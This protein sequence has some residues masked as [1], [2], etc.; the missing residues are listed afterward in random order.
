VV[1]LMPLISI[2]VALLSF[3]IFGAAAFFVIYL[4]NILYAILC[5]ADERMLKS[6]GYN[7]GGLFI[8]ALIFIPAYLY[9]RANLVKQ[10]KLPVMIWCITFAV[11]IVVYIGEL[12]NL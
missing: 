7:T 10:K 6:A 5:I 12:V 8:V 4:F 3:Y 9:M 11:S 2:L 1:A